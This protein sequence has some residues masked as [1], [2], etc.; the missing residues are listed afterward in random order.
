V[1][2]PIVL[3]LAISAALM[4][5]LAA[6]PASAIDPVSLIESSGDA[7]AI[8]SEGRVATLL[9]K[10][11]IHPAVNHGKPAGAA[12]CSNAGAASGNYVLLGWQIGL[13]TFHFNPAT[14]PAGLGNQTSVMQASFNAWSGAPNVNVVGDGTATRHSAN[15]T[16]EI[17][18]GS[19]GGSLATTYTWRWND[20]LVES[21]VVF[22]KGYNWV[23]FGSEGDGCYENAGNVYD[24]RNIG[25]HE[26][27]HVYGLGHPS[28]ARFET[29]YAYGYSGETLKW[30]P[31]S[32]DNAGIQANY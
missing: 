24:V 3:A 20:G 4:L 26:M 13:S 30:S 18:F 12:N 23:N 29:M 14:T 17:M 1:K 7:I 22:N 6:Q 19:T 2:K 11:E 28:G 27:G 5:V 10:H 9:E 32:G 16:G 21:D 8:D 25:T 31:A 15:R